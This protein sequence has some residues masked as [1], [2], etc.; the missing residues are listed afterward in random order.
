MAQKLSRSPLVTVAL[1]AVCLAVVLIYLVKTRPEAPRPGA[2]ALSADA[3]G[4]TP[5][6]APEP[7]KRSR[8]LLGTVVTIQVLAEDTAQAEALAEVGFAEIARLHALLAPVGEQSE[9]A[10]LNAAAGGEPVKIGPDLLA[11]LEEAMLTAQLSGGAFDPTWAAMAPLWDLKDDPPRIPDAAAA[12]AAA[13]RVDCG[14]LEVEAKAGTARLAEAGMAVG[15]G[16]VAKGYAIDRAVLAMRAS[17]GKHLLVDAGG[18]LYASGRK[19]RSRQWSIGVRDPRDR[20]KLL[21][22]I[23]L[24]D[25][26]VTTSG[27]YERFAIVEGKRYHHILDPRTGMP[28][29][30]SR[31]VTVL[32]K[33]AMQADALSTAL[34]VMGP[35]QAI[36]LANRLEGVEALVVDAEG[37]SLMTPGMAKRF[38]RIGP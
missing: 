10:R 1:M 6:P 38:A 21:G 12:T 34:F 31:S 19:G 23:P 26:A 22:K 27:D 29:A 18:D 33:T 25:E 36:K 8:E 5:E 32:A 35:E 4:S 9:V 24:Q 14:K 7:F 16:G 15:L 20:D 28:A 2:A 17:G 3:A 30:G 11:V 37:R 13:G